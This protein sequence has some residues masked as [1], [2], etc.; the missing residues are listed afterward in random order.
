MGIKAF[1]IHLRRMREER[2]HSQQALADLAD[3]AKSSIQRFENAE[4]NP[5]LDALLS[6]AN[7][8]E[9]PLHELMNFSIPKEKAKK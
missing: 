5:T 2:K 4:M 8:L 9:M 3:L 7:A 1:G 6:I